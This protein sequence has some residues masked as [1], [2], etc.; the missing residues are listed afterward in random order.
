MDYGDV[1]ITPQALSCL[2]CYRVYGSIF[3]R[4]ILPLTLCLPDFLLQ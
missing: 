2:G 3:V 4:Q 1:K